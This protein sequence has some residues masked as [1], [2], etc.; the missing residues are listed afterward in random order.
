[1]WKIP[2][3]YHMLRTLTSARINWSEIGHYHS[4]TVNWP[5]SRSS[6]TQ[7]RILP[8]PASNLIVYI[9]MHSTFCSCRNTLKLGQKVQYSI[10]PNLIIFWGTVRALL[11]KVRVRVRGAEYG[12]SKIKLYSLHPWNK[13][14]N[15]WIMDPFHTRYNLNTGACL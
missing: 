9:F 2:S 4:T 13:P 11:W 6:L 1:M 8:S 10:L 15:E 3:K 5:H 14:S 7:S 12:T